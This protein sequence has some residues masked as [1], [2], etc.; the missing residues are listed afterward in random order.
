MS[1]NINNNEIEIAAANE[2]AA[3]EAS[4]NAYAVISANPSTLNFTQ[5]AGSQYVTVACSDSTWTV[6]GG[7]TWC[8]I[9]KIS[10]TRAQITV[11][12]NTGTERRTGVV[13]LNG[14]RVASITVIQ[15]GSSVTYDRSSKITVYKQTTNNNCA[16][17]C[18]CMCVN[19]SPTTVAND[20]GD[21]ALCPANWSKIANKYGYSIYPS[22]GSSS[23]TIS[24]VFSQLKA[25]YPVI[26]QVN[27]GTKEHWVVVT[28]YK[29]N[30]TDMSASNFTCADPWTGSTCALNKATNYSSV[31]MYIVFK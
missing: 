8:T 10:N 11:T 30:G 14:S 29:G 20:L 6:G 27:S 7:G 18:A 1:E 23:A 5:A 9:K 4:T 19:K 28:K 12:A 3:G 2:N 13:C 16:G 24:T 21:A 15:A 31:R 22:T 17:T 26:A 25:G